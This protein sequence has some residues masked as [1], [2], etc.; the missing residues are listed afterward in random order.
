MKYQAI[1]F[2]LDGTLLDTLEDIADAANSVLS[3]FNFPQHDL[4][5]YKYFVGEGIGRL[6][7]RALPQKKFEEDF[8]TLC[9]TLMR[10]E[11][12]KTWTKK[13]HLYPQ[14]PDILDSLTNQ[15]IK[16]AILSNKPDDFTKEMVAK[17][18]MKWQFFIV[19][20]EKPF[21]PK[22]PDPY[23]A[24][25]IAEN[26]KIPPRTFLFLGDSE[27]DMKTALAAGMHPVGVLWG[28]RT[29][30]ELIA[31]GAKVLIKNLSD[32]IKIIIH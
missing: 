27:V 24:L 2:D 15:G 30:E 5:T 23:A 12:S 6:I 19:Q 17:F 10:A 16:M 28:F 1:I 3:R 18:L 8:I 11:Y 9:V 4:Q 7:Q 29:A 21:V 31:S 25:A 32:L 13:T 22:K 20:G 14:V 26:L